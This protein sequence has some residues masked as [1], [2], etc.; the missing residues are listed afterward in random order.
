MSKRIFYGH[1]MQF[2]PRF[3]T[4]TSTRSRYNKTRN[5]FF[6]FHHSSTEKIAE[7]SLSTGSNETL[8]FRAASITRCPAVTNV[9]LFAIPIVFSPQL[10]E[11]LVTTLR[12]LQQHLLQ[13]PHLDVMLLLK[14]LH[15]HIQFFVL[16][17]TDCNFKTSSS[18]C[19]ETICGENS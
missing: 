15:Y 8:C 10:H 2:I 1:M 9:S 5:S 4:E 6:I 13:S 12:Y 17:E 18:L 16:P 3:I 14:V 7:C 11:V 19:T